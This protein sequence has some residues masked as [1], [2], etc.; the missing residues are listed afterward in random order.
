MNENLR[1]QFHFGGKNFIESKFEVSD[2]L[3]HI[4]A[5]SVANFFK[6]KQKLTK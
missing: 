4:T 5:P 3:I 6:L 2:T 1:C